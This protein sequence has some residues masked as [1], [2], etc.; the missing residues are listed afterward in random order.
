MIP[1]LVG[2]R[3]HDHGIG[4]SDSLTVVTCDVVG[5]LYKEDE[6]SYYLAS[7]ICDGSVVDS[8]TEACQVLKA[9]V[10][11]RY[12]LTPLKVRSFG[13]GTLN[14]KKVK[15]TKVPSGRGGKS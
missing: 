7:W 9:T 4:T 15:V 2:L 12:T 3:F 8:N 5:W 14:E 11:E 6:L 13:K 1:L 10:I